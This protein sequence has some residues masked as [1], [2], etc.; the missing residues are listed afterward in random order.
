MRT[1]ALV[2]NEASR[3]IGEK[4]EADG[5]TVVDLP[6]VT[7]AEPFDSAVLTELDKFDW[8]VFPDGFAA[9]YF[10]AALV[11]H[12]IELAELDFLRVAVLTGKTADA[13]TAVSIHADLIVDN[14]DQLLE[15][16]REYEGVTDLRILI[17]CAVDQADSLSKL[18]PPGDAK[19]SALRVYAKEETAPPGWAKTKALLIGGGIDELVFCS[20]TDIETLFQLFKGPELIPILSSIR[21]SAIDIHL[22]DQLRRLGLDPVIFG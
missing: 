18:S 10:A 8:I 5:A 13:V 15:V 22:V 4:L 1:Y 3:H 20:S 6:A 17:P 11:E 7:V 2:L 21:L 12:G 14:Q 16:I 19:V 9:L